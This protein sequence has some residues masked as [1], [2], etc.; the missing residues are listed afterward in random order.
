MLKQLFIVLKKK[1]FFS[2]L[3]FLFFLFIPFQNTYTLISFIILF[4]ANF[5]FHIL[6]IILS[7]LLSSS[8]SYLVSLQ[9]VTTEKGGTK[10]LSFYAKKNPRLYIIIDNTCTHNIHNIYI[11]TRTQCHSSTPLQIITAIP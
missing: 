5:L 1:L 11:Y 3:P 6:I 10:N 2:L 7:S 4:Y 9:S 8:S